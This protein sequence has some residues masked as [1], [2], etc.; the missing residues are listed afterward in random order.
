MLRSTAPTRV[1][2][3]WSARR[4][5]PGCP[6]LTEWALPGT[7][8]L[9]VAA[10]AGQPQDLAFLLSAPSPAEVTRTAH[11]HQHHQGG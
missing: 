1:N 2:L 7:Y 4:S 8:H 6:R 3:T 10:L 11:P 5:E 9:H